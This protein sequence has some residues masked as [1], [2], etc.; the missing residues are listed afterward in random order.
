MEFVD[1]CSINKFKMDLS[2]SSSTGLPVSPDLRILSLNVAANS[3]LFGGLLTLLVSFKPHLVLLQEVACDT[4]TLKN[5]VSALGYDAFCNVVMEG[6]RGLGTAAVWGQGLNVDAVNVVCPDRILEVVCGDL[7]ILNVYAYAGKSAEWIRR[8]FFG[9]D[10]L[11]AVKNAGRPILFGDWNCILDDKDTEA[12]AGNK[13][14]AALGGLVRDLRMVDLWRQFHP[15]KEEFTW[16]RNGF[17]ASRLDRCYVPSESLSL[18]VSVKHAPSLSDHWALLATFSSALVNLVPSPLHGGSVYWKMNVQILKEDDW[19][20]SFHALWDT[21][22]EKKSE[23]EDVATWWDECCK[24]KIKNMSSFYSARRKKIRKDTVDFLYSHLGRAMKSGDWEGV[25]EL[26]ERIKEMLLEDMWGLVIRS[27]FDRNVEEE[28]AGLY[29]VNRERKNGDR[30]NVGKLKV[31]KNGK[32]VIS[33]KVEVEK[34]VMGFF[35]PL[36]SGSHDDKGVDTG[37]VFVQDETF[38]EDFLENVPRLSSV[39]A[40]LL[41]APVSADE[42][43]A[44]VEELPANKS[45]GLDGLPYEF[46]RAVLPVIKTEFLQVLQCVLDRRTLTGSMKMGVTRL[47]PKVSGIPAVDELRPI[48]LLTTDYKLLTKVLVKRLI[49]V[50]P[51]VIKSGQLCSVGENNIMDGA[52]GHL[53]V[54]LHGE[55]V[56]GALGL[57]SLDQWKA[58]DRVYVPYL[59]QVLEKMGFGASWVEWIRMLHQENTTR[60][61]LGD[62]SDPIDLLF[63]V[64]QGDPIAL[65]L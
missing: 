4:E 43:W 45:P 47:L 5:F 50:L 32:K 22:L 16:F 31:G 57:V 15:G 63:S 58:F 19:K 56:V 24:K 41:E 21:L 33:E 23:F 61:I 9:Q 59:L 8:T 12:N 2:S 14:S 54:L 1:F 7:K 55:N 49:P 25:Y 6:G 18:A 34:E 53:S 46:Y 64:R 13:K 3:T 42:L 26:R 28:K 36:F 17:A 35:K 52:V 11:Q 40:D 48:T 60:F 20:T 38:L 39:S 29:H 27:K 65:I 44:V 51:E 10:C 37:K 62:L 30:N